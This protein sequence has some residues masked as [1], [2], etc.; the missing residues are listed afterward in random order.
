MAAAAKAH[1]HPGIGAGRSST[2]QPWAMHLP[3]G[4]LELR[5]LLLA[6]GSSAA[7]S[8]RV[9]G[10]PAGRGCIQRYSCEQPRAGG[11]RREGY[12]AAAASAAECMAGADAARTAKGVPFM[13]AAISSSFLEAEATS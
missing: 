10:A 3:R 8:R 12:W 9:Q 13:C 4:T 5:R 6:D 11:R 1:M 2:A 7:I